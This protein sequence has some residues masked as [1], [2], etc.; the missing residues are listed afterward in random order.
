MRIKPEKKVK[1][2]AFSSVKKKDYIVD[3]YV[4][5]AL[6]TKEFKFFF[7]NKN[8]SGN[9]TE[10]LHYEDYKG[11]SNILVEYDRGRLHGLKTLSVK[12]RCENLKE[13]MN[14][15]T[16]V[17]DMPVFENLEEL[18]LYYL[19]DLK[20]LC[21]GELPPGTLCSL[22]L[23][24]VVGCRNLGNVL[25]PSKLLQKLPN[26][27]KLF[28]LGTKVEYV[29]GCEGFEP[30]QTNLREMDLWDLDAV[31]S[32]CNGPAPR[33]MF[34]TL[35]DLVIDNCNFQ[36]S[37][38]TI[39]VAQCLFQ[40]EQ[41]FVSQ[42]PFLERLIE[43]RRESLN[44]NK[45]VLPNLKSLCLQYLPMLYKGSATIDFECPSL[46][47]LCIEDCPHLSF[48]SSASDHFHSRKQDLFNLGRIT[49][50]DFRLFAGNEGSDGQTVAEQSFRKNLPMLYRGSAKQTLFL[51]RC[52]RAITDVLLIPTAADHVYFLPFP[53]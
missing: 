1:N 40:L 31:R 7:K 6:L 46:E 24:D 53:I 41:L 23:L 3:D 28:C 17:P 12:G 29:F 19:D 22:K 14:A 27:E 13:L 25:L 9:N 52:Q 34:Q 36:G 49:K 20:Q 2:I 32:I 30:D 16:C 10:R 48:P 37:L 15:I 50:W 26:L 42:C 11:L 39:D 45:T 21:V 5:L 4:D 8:S 38:F 33:G 47:I 44:N 43:A 51:L 35:N 18:Y